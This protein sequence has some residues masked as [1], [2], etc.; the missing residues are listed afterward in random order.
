MVH[1]VIWGDNFSCYLG[2]ESMVGW[3]NVV[4]VW[5]EPVRSSEPADQRTSERVSKLEKEMRMEERKASV[6]SKGSSVCKA[7]KMV[8]R[9]S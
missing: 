2:L 1:F 5:F 4:C 8:W 3:R 6:D 7:N 9:S